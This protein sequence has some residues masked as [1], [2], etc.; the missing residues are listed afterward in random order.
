MSAGI[1]YNNGSVLTATAAGNNGDVLTS[2]G[3]G[4]PPIFAPGGGGSGGNANSFDVYLTSTLSGVTGDGTYVNP[5]IYDGVNYNV[6]SNYNPATGLYTAPTTG[7]YY[8][9]A[10][11]RLDG[12]IIANTLCQGQLTTF[13]ATITNFYFNPY[14]ISDSGIVVFNIYGAVPMT[15][16]D[17]ALM[18]LF[19][20]GNGTA[21]VSVFGGTSGW[22]NFGGWQIS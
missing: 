17:Q 10:T 2:Q 6:G 16:G 1:I 14:P 12:L 11:C 13:S 22:Q 3:S 7:R 21:N 9:Y 4:S 5:I 15:A 19:V 8:F 18:Q 20:S